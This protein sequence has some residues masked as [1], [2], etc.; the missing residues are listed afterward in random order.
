MSESIKNTNIH[1]EA[2]KESVFAT[3]KGNIRKKK[4]IGLS[5]SLE[6]GKS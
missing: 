2:E 1:S 6:Q 5:E 4:T 3:S